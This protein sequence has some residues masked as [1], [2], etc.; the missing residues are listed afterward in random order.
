MVTVPYLQR[1]L[2]KLVQSIRM[3][4]A[5]LQDPLHLA[6]IPFG[7]CCRQSFTGIHLTENHSTL[8]S[9]LFGGKRATV[10]TLLGHG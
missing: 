8:S 2:A 7:C 3:H 5:F 10:G 4:S 6:G 1:S 9:C